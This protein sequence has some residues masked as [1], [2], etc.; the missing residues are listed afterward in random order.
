MSP[1]RTGASHYDK[2]QTSSPFKMSP[3]RKAF[4]GVES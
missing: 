2:S 4:T 1:V 3:I